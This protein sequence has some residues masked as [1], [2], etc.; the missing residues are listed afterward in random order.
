MCEGI[1]NGQAKKHDLSWL[2]KGTQTNSLLWVTSCLYNRN[3]AP[4]ISRVGWIIFCQRTRKHLDGSFWE[5]SSLE[6]SYRAKLL[7][8][9]LLHLFALILPEFYKISSRKATLSCD[10]LWALMLSSHNHQH[11]EPSTACSDIHHNLC[12][13][14]TFFTGGF[15]YQH[16]AGHMDTVLY[17]VIS[18]GDDRN[19]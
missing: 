3:H 18:V 10:N 17:A 1:D 9:C 8:L 15:K 2:A 6:T 16:V 11:I 5:K 12:S 14:K 19:S 4:I 13:T 7:G